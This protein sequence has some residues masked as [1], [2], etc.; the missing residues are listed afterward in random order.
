MHAIYVENYESEPFM[1]AFKTYFGEI[2]GRERNWPLL[3]RQMNAEREVTRAVLL[4]DG[5]TAVGF[6]LFCPLHLSCPFFTETYGYIRELWVASEYRRQ[7]NGRLL[8]ALAEQDLSNRKIARVLLKADPRATGFYEKQGY[9]V[10]DTAVSEE[11][12]MY[13]K[14]ISR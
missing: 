14:H 2:S 4:Q 7:G 13:T 6:V 9:T 12:V 10:S 5:G 8:L 3:F 11:G 1:T